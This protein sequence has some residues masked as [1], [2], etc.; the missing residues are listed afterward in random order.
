MNPQ[1]FMRPALL[2]S[3]LGWNPRIGH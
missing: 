3:V 2:E 1:P